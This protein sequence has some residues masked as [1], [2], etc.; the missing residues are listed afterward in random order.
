MAQKLPI[1][2]TRKFQYAAVAGAFTLLSYGTREFLKYL[3]N[4]SQDERDAKASQ[5]ESETRQSEDILKSE[6]RQKEAIL[7]HR[8]AME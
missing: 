1:Y 7:K 6:L 5:K 3:T 4:K 2:K 8:L